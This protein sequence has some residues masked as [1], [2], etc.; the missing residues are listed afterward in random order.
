M[1]DI[2]SIVSRKFELPKAELASKAI[3]SF[4]L[5]EKLVFWFF[6]LIFI[7]SSGLL[8]W[9]VNAS[10]LVSVP[11]QG[12]ELIEGIIGGARFINPLLAMSDADK[13]MSFLIYSGL[14]KVSPDGSLSKDLAESYTISPD[15]LTYDFVINPKAV[16]HDGEPVTADDVIFTI[17]KAQDPS[18]KSPRR[19]NWE[20]ITIQKV[21]D[22][23][24]Q[25][26][27]KQPYGPFLEN[28]TLG[29]LPEH[30]WKSTSVENF[31]FSKFNTEPVGSGP[32]IVQSVRSNSEKIPVGYNLKSFNNYT[33][34]EPYITSITIKFYPDEI[35]L[36]S[37]YNKGDIEGG[38]GFGAKVANDLEDQGANIERS[39]LPRTFAVFF[40]QNQAPVF[41]DKSVRSALDRSVN[42][43]SIVT[44]V[45]FG[46]GSVIDGPIPNRDGISVVD[47][48]TDEER[49]NEAS[50]IL[51]KGGWSRNSSTSPEWV[52]KD[53]KGKVTSTLAFSLSTGDA[54]ELKAA[55]QMIADDWTKLGAKVDLQVFETGDLNQNI[56][57]PRKYDSIF[58]GE[59]V[60]RDLDFYPFWHSSQRT[61]PGLNIALYVNSKVDKILE[62]ARATSD[63]TE[64]DEK[65]NSFAS[66]IR[67]EVPV[68][69]VYAPDFLYVIPKKVH[70]I[71]IG[72]LTTPG[73][74]FA[75]VN[76]WY[77]N[78][79]RIWKIFN[80]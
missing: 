51:I 65:Y 3:R 2:S 70:N 17:T 11:D 79:N 25:F 34:G 48:R 58:F 8:L 7:F 33:K 9:R 41:A 67:D 42:K 6:T 62:D 13:D 30:I 35:S 54:P 1:K 59:I 38:Y 78:T 32:Y 73:E 80:R 27:L 24:V 10:Y 26:V 61:N 14:M 36:V 16:F 72:E 31:A 75:N 63:K 76:E 39:V 66:I 18:L 28:T 53:K 29:I 20:G 40:N 15:G 5:T 44:Q 60:G 47:S 12:G 50:E 37:A 4:G 77:V 52:K 22:L 19:S 49:I 43:N 69:F 46:Y 57:R 23:E 21:S 45:L 71:H 56:I 64:R 55:A 68:V 74:R